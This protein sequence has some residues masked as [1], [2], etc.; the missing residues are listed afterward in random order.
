MGI[1]NRFWQLTKGIFGSPSDAFKILSSYAIGCGALVF[2]FYAAARG[3]NVVLQTMLCIFG[4]AIGWCL[5]LYLTPSSENERKQLS[6]AGKAFLAIVSG[7]GLGKAG[8]IVEQ[9]KTWFPP[10][11]E[12]AI[13]AL[14]FLST[15]MIGALFTYISRLFVK[16]DLETRREQ[17]AKTIKELKDAINRLEGQN[18]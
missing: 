16:G 9:L 5:G 14:L 12:S 15:L 1:L 8:E 11:E 6:E 7:F 2:C 4:G 13:R 10:S 17:R 3:P 18:E